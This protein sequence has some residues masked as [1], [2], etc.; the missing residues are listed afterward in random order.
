MNTK[1]IAKYSIKATLRDRS[2]LFWILFFPMLLLTFFH[3]TFSGFD[4]DV[5]NETKI[6]V[7]VEKGSLF[8]IVAKDIKFIEVKEMYVEE[9]NLALDNKEITS[10][11]DKNLNLKTKSSD[12]DSVIIKTIVDQVKQMLAMGKMPSAY[13]MDKSYIEKKN[14]SIRPH[15]LATLSL[16]ALFTSYAANAGLII[17]EMVQANQTTFAQRINVSPVRKNTMIIV[18]LIT[19]LFVFLLANIILLLFLRFVLGNTIISNF[20]ATYL[21]MS[22]GSLL[23]LAYGMFVGV[24]TNKNSEYKALVVTMSTLFLA[25]LSGMMNFQTKDA[26]ESKFPILGKINPIALMTTEITK[27]NVLN[28]WDTYLQALGIL[29]LMT[30][31]MTL[32]AG[33]TLRRTKYDSI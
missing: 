14:S 24:I 27:I 2:F 12:T 30:V 13:D 26:I 23:G 7:G 29:L 16:L 8:T 18:N 22:V 19:H 32:L 5:V 33:A 31:I 15:M 25:F 10:F 17:T 11:V 4:K 1:D 28:R 21:L 6:K 20:P 3:V 9:G